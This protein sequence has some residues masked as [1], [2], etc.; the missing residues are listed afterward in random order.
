M[1][2]GAR[3]PVF[4]AERIVFAHDPEANRAIIPRPCHTRR[5]PA[6][7]LVPFI[8]VDGGCE[9]KGKL[10]R[11]LERASQELPKNGRATQDPSSSLLSPSG[12]VALAEDVAPGLPQAHMYMT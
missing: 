11:V 8:A 4:D 10:R 5:C 7:W 6:P 12:L 1:G 2:I 3:H 9:E